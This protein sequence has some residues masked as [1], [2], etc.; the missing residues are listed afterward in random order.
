MVK[1]NTASYGKIKLVLKQNRFFVESAYPDILQVLL[2]DPEIKEA[3]IQP[4]ESSSDNATSDNVIQSGKAPDRKDIQVA[5]IDNKPAG[6]NSN[7]DS[8]AT[9]AD[10]AEEDS[11]EKVDHAEKM[12]DV[13]LNVEDEGNEELEEEKVFSFEIAAKEVE[14]GTL[15]HCSSVTTS[16]ECSTSMQ[17]ARSPA[18]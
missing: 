14:V 17:P 5:G 1:E 4:S 3:I 18:N 13:Q 2:K 9:N 8:L 12:I 6:S 7:K 15:Q 11:L 16:I 10:A